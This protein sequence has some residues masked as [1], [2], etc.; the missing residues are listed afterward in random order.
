[1]CTISICHLKNKQNKT[2]QK[3]GEKVYTGPLLFTENLGETEVHNT[4]SSK[5]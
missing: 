1:M 2:K 4:L 3:L 5:V